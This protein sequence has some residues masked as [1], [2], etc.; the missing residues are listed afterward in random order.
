M[1]R[2]S[3][4]PADAVVGQGIPHESAAL[5]VTGTALYTDDLAGRTPDLLHAWPVQSPHAR[6]AVT[7]MHVEAAYGVD[8]VVRVLTAADVPGLNDGGVKGDEPLF[9]Q[10]ACYVGH[11]M[12]WVLGETLEGAGYRSAE[13][14]G[15]KLHRSNVQTG[16]WSGDRKVCAIGVRL[17]RMR[18]SH[19]STP[20]AS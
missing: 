11:A 6:A 3:Q 20:S 17:M 13:A 9:P 10:E 8:G 19:T 18:V 15:T 1:S 14:I 4:R 7:A 16:V 5:H 12:C 2:L